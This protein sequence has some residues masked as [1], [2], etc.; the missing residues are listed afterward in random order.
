MVVKYKVNFKDLKE[1]ETKH[2]KHFRS[3][4]M[5]DYT[6]LLSQK[7]IQCFVVNTNHPNGDE[8]HCI[9]EN[10]LIYIYNYESKRFITVLH[11]RPSQ[12]KRYYRLLKIE[13]PK[14]IKRLAREC[15]K[16]NEKMNYNNK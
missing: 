11:P 9:N 15:H 13:V 3:K 10:G 8:I 12:L 2:I 4:R 6:P 14:N 16:R 5:E 7:F 1:R